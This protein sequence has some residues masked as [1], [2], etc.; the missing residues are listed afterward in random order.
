MLTE[1]T[2]D[3]IS[4]YITP[5][6]TTFSQAIDMY[7]DSLSNLLNTN[8]E[9]NVGVSNQKTFDN[10]VRLNN[11]NTNVQENDTSLIIDL[12]YRQIIIDKNYSDNYNFSFKPEYIFRNNNV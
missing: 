10:F 5:F 11:I 2:G 1:F 8:E 6:S 12:G 3:K 9:N 7:Y 4:K